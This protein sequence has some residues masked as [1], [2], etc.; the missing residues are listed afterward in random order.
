MQGE[1]PGHSLQ[2]GGAMPDQ[3]IK[4]G[5]RVRIREIIPGTYRYG[6]THGFFSYSMEP[7]W[8]KEDSVKDIT[9]DMVY[10][11]KATSYYFL[12]QWLEL[13][14]PKKKINLRPQNV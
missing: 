5:D 4:V 11:D 12:K 14:H 8:G 3:V 6:N 1:K 13:A 7:L 9:G 2:C 10:L